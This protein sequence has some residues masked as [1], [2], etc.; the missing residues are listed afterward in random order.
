LKFC[1][2]LF[3][4]IPEKGEGVGVG[5]GRKVLG[6]GKEQMGKVKEGR[7]EGRKEGEG[8]TKGWSGGERKGGWERNGCVSQ[9]LKRGYGS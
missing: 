4:W 9:I 5:R 3:I 8:S 7:L 6:K 2:E 1:Q